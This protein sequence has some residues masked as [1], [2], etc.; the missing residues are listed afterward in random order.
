[1]KG[2]KV[3]AVRGC[4]ACVVSGFTNSATEGSIFVIAGEEREKKKGNE[5]TQ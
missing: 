5:A 4:E 1:M 2:V 3:G